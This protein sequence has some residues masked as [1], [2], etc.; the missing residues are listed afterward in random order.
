MATR[1]S[2]KP[3]R[4]KQPAVDRRADPATAS[5]LHQLKGLLAR[6]IGL[7]RRAGRWHVVLVER[8]VKAAAD[9]PATPSQMRSELRA[10]LLAHRI[11]HA[12]EVMR[13]LV[14]VHDEMGKRGWPGVEAL[15]APLLGKALVQA[16]MLASE[17]PSPA[18]STF[19]D[20]L[21]LVRAGA[22]LREERAATRAREAQ[23]SAAMPL[24][25]LGAEAHD[26]PSSRPG[27]PPAGPDT[28]VSEATQEEFEEVERSWVEEP[29]AGAAPAE[30]AN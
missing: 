13:H 12:A 30:P 28:V 5:S 29:R 8:R 16:K 27:Q 19:I 7:E 17:D 25:P 6:P 11:D 22:E 1:S 10:R 26:G 15:P 23:A 18:L 21:R 2:A 4:H 20:R 14:F 3:R 9:L 24:V